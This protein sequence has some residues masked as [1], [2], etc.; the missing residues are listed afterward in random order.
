MRWPVLKNVSIENKHKIRRQ[1]DGLFVIA[2]AGFLDPVTPVSFVALTFR[3][4]VQ[5]GGSCLRDWPFESLYTKP[6]L[7]FK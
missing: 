2:D 6:P 4:L 7:L 1:G 3:S 5:S